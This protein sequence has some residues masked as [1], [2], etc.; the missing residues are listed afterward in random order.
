MKKQ[1]SL[2]DKTTNFLFYNTPDGKIKID[3][4]LHKE[5]V[6]LTQKKMAELFD[7]DRSVITKHLKNIFDDGELNKDSV[8]A[9]I[10]HT[11][12]DEKTYNTQFYN[13]DAI[14]SVG[15]RVNSKKAT[16]FRVWATKILKE[17]YYKRIFHR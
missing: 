12:L 2:K 3:V 9:K 10:A 15:Y 11:A 4:F 6:W 5:N 7:V 1:I 8:C 13:L 14:I 16:Q 17:F